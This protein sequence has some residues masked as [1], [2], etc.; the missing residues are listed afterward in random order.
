MRLPEIQQMVRSLSVENDALRKTMKE[1]QRA[2]T[3]LSQ[4]NG[5][6]ETRLDQSTTLNEA[7]SVENKGKQ[8]PER[9]RAAEQEAP[10]GFVLP[11]L[12]LPADV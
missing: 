9:Q 12:N 10:S 3:A 5:K 8:Q 7:V 6:L 1:L 11:D 4:E 2:C